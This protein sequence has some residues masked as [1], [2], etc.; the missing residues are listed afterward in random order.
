MASYFR[1]F[2]RRFRWV[3][4]FFCAFLLCVVGPSLSG[5]VGMAQNMVQNT[6]QNT[7]PNTVQSLANEGVTLYEAGDFAA[8]IA[9]WETALA[10]L[11]PE[12][13]SADRATLLENLARLYRRLGQSPKSLT[14]WSQA[15]QMAEAMGEPMPLGRLMSEQAQTY[16]QLGQYRRAIALLCGAHEADSC[17]DRSAI[18][19]AQATNDTVG[20]AAA[21]GS[22]GEALRLQRDYESAIA[23]LDQSLA[24]SKSLDKSDS[25]SGSQSGYP[26]AYQSAAL[27]S[28]G[29]VYT[30]KAQAQYR[31]IDFA[32]AV[33]DD[34]NAALLQ[35]KAIE[36]DRAAQQSFEESL[37]LAQQQG[38]VDSQWRVQLSLIPL[39]RRLDEPG[40][41][42]SA[43]QAAQSLLPQV[44][45][46][47]EKV[48]GTLTLANLIQFDNK[49][50]A[51]TLFSQCF[52][53]GGNAQAQA[54]LTNA[55]EQAQQLQDS[56]GESFALGTLG[57]WYEC[58]GDL[59][60]S[61]ALTQ[62]AEIAADQQLQGR[63][64]LYLWQW[65]TGRLLHR[66]NQIE[67]AKA[68]YQQAVNTLET[69]RNELL[70]SDRE[71][72]FDFRDTVEPVYRELMALQLA[73]ASPQ[74][75]ASPQSKQAAPLAPNVTLGAA[76]TTL[77]SLKLAELQN[78]FGSD[79]EIVP[80]AETQRGLTGENSGTAVIT[81][82]TFDDRT[83]VIASFPSG[84]RQIAWIA[85][86]AQ[87]IRKDVNAFRRQLE[88]YYDPT[89]FDTGR[90]EKIYDWLIRPFA[91]QLAS[92]QIDTLVFVSDG[93]VRSIPMSA[94]HDGQQ[95]LVERYATATVPTLSLTA[96]SQLNRSR[97]NML[98]M[99]LTEPATVGETS[100]DE[101]QYVDQEISA[102]QT[103]VAG[104]T[105]LRNQAF[106]EQSLTQALGENA[107]SVLHMAT[108]AQFGVDPEDTFLVTGQSEKLTFG[109]M[110]RLIRSVS[111]NDEPIELLALTACETAI[112]DDRAALGIGGVV[113]RAGAKSA[114][115]SLWAVNDAVTAQ[116]SGQFY[117]NLVN[118]QMGKAKALQAAQIEMIQAGARPSGW[119][120]LIVVGNWQ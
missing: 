36:F 63:D 65:Q 102:I 58:Q 59:A 56:Q 81:S 92:E 113:I 68:A 10:Q 28:L 54:L 61:S 87:T 11:S 98:I 26:S 13:P 45:A 94:L 37:T 101:L 67:G 29:T 115:A 71:L 4:V 90:A 39:Y 85:E 116:I 1:W 24:V 31:R 109:E 75:K 93:I 52:S 100:Y 55:I 14:Y 12:V 9:Q 27:Y 2:Q 38:D 84:D 83:A 53:G 30:R 5:Q 49:T 117:E 111:A 79:C 88:D 80:F 25:Q 20:N 110:D 19:I 91:S 66:Q 108:H 47:H 15:V 82:I 43:Q 3:I 70:V 48:N 96:S 69:I 60:R 51:H 104:T 77:E 99:G 97:I 21:L 44:S 105:V 41:A 103:V 17:Q 120:P 107:Y 73:E 118:G 114:I 6:A 40:S 89:E 42:A 22:F 33:E 57:H 32:T 23:A 78:Y 64:S 7:I 74:L 119:S 86:T 50:D 76:I 62:Q 95:F 112:G 18:A 34:R 16:A 35:A 106:T 72:Q 46:S 8:A